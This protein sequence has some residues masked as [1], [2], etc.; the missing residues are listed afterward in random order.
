MDKSK[1][2]DA[3]FEALFKQAVIDKFVEEV[4]SIPPDEELKK[5]YSFSPQFDLRMKKFFT[6]VRRKELMKKIARYTRRVAIILLIIS[7]LTFGA[8]LT[9][10]QV[11]ATVGNVIV[12]WFEL[13]MSITFQREGPHEP[14]FDWEESADL[15]PEWLPD[16]FEIISIETVLNQTA[17]MISNDLGNV[18]ELMYRPGD[19]IATVSIDIEQLIIEESLINESLAFIA[20]STHEDFPNIIVFVFENHIVEIHGMISIDKLLKIADSMVVITENGS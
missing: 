15:R 9:N 10:P 7:T 1:T 20:T 6:R 8:L 4:E 16:G 3:V 14:E 11:R 18:L 12:E 13:F 5:T 19:D 2:D 17:I